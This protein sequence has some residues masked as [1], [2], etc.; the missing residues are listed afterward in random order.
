M[1][2][3]SVTVPSGMNVT[4]YAVTAESYFI[5][6]VLGGNPTCAAIG[7]NSATSPFIPTSFSTTTKSLLTSTVALVGKPSN[8]SSLAISAASPTSAKTL[9]R[10]SFVTSPSTTSTAFAG[11][12][13]G[14]KVGIGVAVPLSL[15]TFYFLG[16]LLWIRSRRQKRLVQER[17]TQ[18]ELG[19]EARAE[20]DG[21]DVRYE[22]QGDGGKHELLD[23]ERSQEFTGAKAAR[24]L[25]GGEHSH[26]LEAP[27]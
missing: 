9:T 27:T 7:V 22:I 24:E 25:T 8:T 18:A 17:V 15:I 3:F 4:A 13:I 26:E 10:T 14:S 2:A 16:T 5:D 23:Q 11:L 12:S 20:V 19:S 21:E 6:T 1:S